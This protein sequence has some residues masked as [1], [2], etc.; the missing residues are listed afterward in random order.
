MLCSKPPV[1]T[2]DHNGHADSTSQGPRHGMG[3]QMAF[4]TSRWHTEPSHTHTHL[5]RACSACTSA[6]S[7]A[8]MHL[9]TREC[10][11]TVCVR[12]LKRTPNVFLCLE[13]DICRSCNIAIILYIIFCHRH[14]Q[15]ERQWV[16]GCVWC[17]F[18]CLV[19]ICV[20]RRRLVCFA[21]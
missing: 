9:H 3:D 20:C 11:G 5:V 8:F 19:C 6:F 21:V 2:G 15:G 4:H 18:V 13:E 17:M 1:A 10:V 14:C 7:H 16:G 12:V